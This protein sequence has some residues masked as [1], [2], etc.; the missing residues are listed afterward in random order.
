VKRTRERPSIGLVDLL[1]AIGPEFEHRNT[2]PGQGGRLWFD[3]QRTD[4]VGEDRVAPFV[5]RSGGCRLAA[6]GVGDEDR[7]TGGQ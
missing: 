4:I 6:A 1:E 7:Y 2:G 5:Q 3:L